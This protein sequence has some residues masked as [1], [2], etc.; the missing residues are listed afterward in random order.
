MHAAFEHPLVGLRGVNHPK[1]LLSGD[2]G[3]EDQFAQPFIQLGG[4]LMYA[5]ERHD[6]ALGPFGH[7]PDDD[8]AFGA[9]TRNR[10]AIIAFLRLGAQSADGTEG[11]QKN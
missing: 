6:G 9:E 7:I 10:Y 11:Q 1:I 5:S 4:N 2:V 3:H 8:R